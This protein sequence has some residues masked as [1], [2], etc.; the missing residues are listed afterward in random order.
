[1]KTSLLLK[2]IFS[3]LILIFIGSTVFVS[4]KSPKQEI[5]QEIK[6]EIN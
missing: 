1:M 4:Y 6:I 3:M 2:I 5:E